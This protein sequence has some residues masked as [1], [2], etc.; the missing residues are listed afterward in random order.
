MNDLP[1]K[2][3]VWHGPHPLPHAGSWAT[4]RYPQE[5][6]EYVKVAALPGMVPQ[7]RPIETAPKDGTEFQVW[8]SKKNGH[9][10]W[11]PRAR[12]NKNNCFQ[13]WGRVDYDIDGWEIY[14]GLE[15]TH[16]MPLPE[17]PALSHE[18]GE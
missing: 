12:Y 2:I 5:A 13:L 7:W 11:D 6:E 10:F 9:G 14:P 18:G 8:L 17:A 16:W 4:T 1:G 3:M 15:P